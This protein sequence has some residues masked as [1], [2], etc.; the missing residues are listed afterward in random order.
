MGFTTSLCPPLPPWSPLP[1]NLGVCTDLFFLVDRT[2]KKINTPSNITTAIESQINC[3]S[4]INEIQEVRSMISMQDSK[5]TQIL[6]LISNNN[7]S[8]VLNDTTILKNN[9]CNDDMVENYQSNNNAILH[10]QQQ[11]NQVEKLSEEK[12]KD[13]VS[14]VEDQ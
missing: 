5:I 11:K 13:M 14:I 6:T 4:Q 7:E 3:D 1:P 10:S 2:N 12:A 9:D 8:P